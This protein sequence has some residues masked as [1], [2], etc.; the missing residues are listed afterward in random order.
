MA[1]WNTDNPAVGNQITA[2]IA[3]IEENLQEL[4]DVITA[5]TNGTLGTTTAA[6]FQV[7]AVST[8]AIL[9]DRARFEW[10]DADEIYI[11][12]GAYHHVG[13]A[14]TGKSQVVYWNTKLTSDIGSPVVSDWYYLYIDDTA[15]IELD[16]NLL[17][18]DQLL[19]SNTEPAWSEAKHGWYNG[20]DKAIFAVLT[21]G[22]SNI[23][24]FFHDGDFFQFA[25][26]ITSLASADKSST[27]TDNDVTLSAPKFTTQVQVT[28]D[29]RY[30]DATATYSWRTNGQTA[31]T[32]H[33]IGVVTAATTNMRNTMR[34]TTN[35]SQAIEVKVAGTNTNTIGVY[36][37][38][39]YFPTGM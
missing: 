4:H 10:K 1:T 3:D 20:E 31:S 39:W 22:S 18:T 2:D 38:G 11:H 33:A 28:F 16:T 29:C 7:D 5:I 24:E 6:D 34:V 13:D 32:G 23:I 26:L 21:D 30:V 17:T 19:W 36:T 35:S 25:D 15:V 8:P 9:L 14:T 27:F 37:E 12:A